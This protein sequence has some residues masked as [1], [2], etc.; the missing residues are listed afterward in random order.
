MEQS[1]HTIFYIHMG[2][3]LVNVNVDYKGGVRYVMSIMDK[4]IGK[5]G[6]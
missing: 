4:N 3:E 6:R 5:I 2:V 1:I